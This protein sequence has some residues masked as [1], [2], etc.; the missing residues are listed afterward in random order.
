MNAF[1][2][3]AS[4]VVCSRHIR[5][6]FE[7]KL[8]SLLGSKS[9]LRSEILGALHDLMQCDD[10][11]GYDATLASLHTGVL[12]RGPAEF[13]PYCDRF[14]FPLLR[15][16]AA[17]GKQAWTNNNCE[18][19]NNV[20]KRYTQFTVQQLPDLISKIKELIVSQHVEADRAMI[21]RG[22]LALQP[23]HSRHRLT[24]DQ[25]KSMSTEQ[26]RKASDA[27]FRLPSVPSSTSSDGLLTVP[28]TPGAGKKPHQRKRPRNAKTLTLH[29]ERF[30]A[31]PDSASR[32]AS[33]T[34]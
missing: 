25:W 34:D 14:V 32:S 13:V 18:S 8:D 6:N 31:V 21:G 11:I 10:V 2:P 22:D 4:T 30:K 7:K 27:C 28:T 17:V 24:V 3:S 12:A 26:R 20:L 33:D 9:A 23:T 29:R 15:A 5:G 19:L 16:N 1:F